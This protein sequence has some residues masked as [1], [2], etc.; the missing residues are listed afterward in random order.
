MQRPTSLSSFFSTNQKHRHHQAA[1]GTPCFDLQPAPPLFTACQ[2][3][4]A[5]LFQWLI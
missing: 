4:Q 2:P 5:K 3:V 1:F